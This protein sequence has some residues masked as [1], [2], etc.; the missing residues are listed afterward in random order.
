MADCICYFYAECCANPPC[1]SGR[2]NKKAHFT[3][4]GEKY[5]EHYTEEMGWVEKFIGRINDLG[6]EV[7]IEDQ[8]GRPIVKDPVEYIKEDLKIQEQG[9]EIRKKIG[10]YPIPLRWVFYYG[11]FFATL[12]FGIYGPGYQASD[13]VYIQ[14]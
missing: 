9:V 6:G 7:K 5:K 2:K 3:K 4:L 1:N 14:F 10:Q 13:F 12:V 8:K 11:L